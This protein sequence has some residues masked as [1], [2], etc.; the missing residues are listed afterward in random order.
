M[1]PQIDDTIDSIQPSLEIPICLIEQALRAEHP[2]EI[3]GVGSS[4]PRFLMR[5][6]GQVV[7]RFSPAAQGQLKDGQTTR[8]TG[9]SGVVAS[10]VVQLLCPEAQH[11]RFLQL[12]VISL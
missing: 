8:S 6:I 11:L 1:A 9:N 4:Y 10:R 7:A 5:C 12:T 3:S 2:G